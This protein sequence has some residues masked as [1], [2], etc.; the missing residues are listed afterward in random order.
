MAPLV[1]GRPEGLAIVRVDDHD[2]GADDGSALRV[3]DGAIERSSGGDL[4]EQQ[5]GVEEKQRE[6][7]FHI[8]CPF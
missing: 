7:R 5:S 2:L 8:V 1:G 4:G 6:N 3:G